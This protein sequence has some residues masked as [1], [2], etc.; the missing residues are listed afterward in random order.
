METEESTGSSTTLPEPEPICLTPKKQLPAIIPEHSY[1]I[2]ES[3]RCLKRKLDSATNN[4]QIMKKKLRISQQKTRRLKRNVSSLKSIVQDLRKKNLMSMAAAEMLEKTFSGVPREILE[5]LIK[6]KN[7]QISRKKYSPILRSFALTLQFYSTKAYNYV[8][9]TFNLALP[10]PS[11]IRSWFS[12]INGETGFTSEAFAALH[13]RVKQA[14]VEK[15]EVV[16]S[17]MLDEMAIRKH[18]EWDGKRFRGFVDVGTDIQDDSA[19]VATEAL[20][21]MAVCLTEHW[22]IPLGY[23][24]ISN[25]SGQERANLV[26]QCVMKLNDVGVRTVSLTCDG[27]SCHFTMMKE[28]GASLEYPNIKPYFPHPADSSKKIYVLLDVCHM[29]KLTRNMVCPVTNP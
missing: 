12:Q 8:R 26:K 29:L 28:L 19:P 22:K 21:F 6:Q 17:I 5:R 9:S 14:A 25:M 11:V 7:D 16:C 27:P 15:K 1:A 4:I 18:V 20:V 2:H 13:A 23:F 10:H 3:P 24:F